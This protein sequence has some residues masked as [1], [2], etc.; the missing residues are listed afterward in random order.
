MKNCRLGGGDFLCMYKGYKKVISRQF[1]MSWQNGKVEVE[2]HD[3][4]GDVQ[5]LVYITSLPKSGKTILQRHHSLEKEI[6][7]SFTKSKSPTKSICSIAL[8]S[9]RSPPRDKVVVDLL[10]FMFLDDSKQSLRIFHI[11]FLNALK[12]KKKINILV[13]LY[14]E[15]SS[16]AEYVQSGMQEQPLY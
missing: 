9:L 16:M 1:V 3:F 12:W 6:E 13:F 11:A 8:S 15:L 5:L 10:C 2:R 4:L 7:F 14:A